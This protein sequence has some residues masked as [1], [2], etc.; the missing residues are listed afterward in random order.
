MTARGGGLSRSVWRVVRDCTVCC[1]GVCVCV[2]V[3]VGTKASES[4]YI[5]SSSDAHH[6]GTADWPALYP[7]G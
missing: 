4:T 3:R 5:L 7:V 6:S 1:M 2:C